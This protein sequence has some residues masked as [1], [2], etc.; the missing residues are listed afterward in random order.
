M[1]QVPKRKRKYPHPKHEDL[2]TP[3]TPEV[4]ELFER[5][6]Q[7]YGTWS[8]VGWITNTNMKVLRCMRC[9]PGTAGR[10]AISHSKLDSMITATGVGSVHD[11]VWFTAED[12][13][14]LGIWK[15]VVYRNGRKN[16]RL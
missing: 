12:L 6:K 10:K 3:V 7:K 9:R 4:L 15:D 2:Y 1:V 16:I 13:V 14:A 5:M 11:F 8:D